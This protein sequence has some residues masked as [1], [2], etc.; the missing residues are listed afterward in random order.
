M[1]IRKTQTAASSFHLLF[2][3]K[4]GSSRTGVSLMVI[5][6]AINTPADTSFRWRE[7]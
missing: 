2:K 6:N 4:Y 1:A 7:K 5:A 3:A